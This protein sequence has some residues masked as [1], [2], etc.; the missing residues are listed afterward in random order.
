MAGLMDMFDDPQL[1]LG[2]GLLAA[3]APRA[4]AAGFGQRLM[5]GFNSAS[6][7]RDA[8][9]KRELQQI[10]LDEFKRKIDLEKRMGE[11]AKK[12]TTPAVA[13]V[14][15]E[16]QVPLNVAGD[17]GPNLFSNSLSN[18]STPGVAAVEAKPA[19][20]D[21]EGYLN[22]LSTV[23]PLKALEERA[24]LLPD[25]KYLTVGNTVV[26]TGRTG[27][28][29]VFTAPEKPPEATSDWKNYQAGLKDPGFNSWLTSQ[30]SAKAPK[31]AV[32]LKDPT[33][34][35][36]ASLEFQDKARA[37]FKDDETIAQQYNAMREAVKTPSAQGDT[38][39][40]YSFFKVLDPQSTVREGEL[41]LVMSSRSIPQKFKGYAQR[42]ANGQVL[43]QPE[44]EDLL[45]QAERQVTARIP[46]AERERKNYSANAKMLQLNP[47]DI[48]PN[49]Y[50]GISVMGSGQRA[51]SGGNNRQIFD[52]AD[53]I[54]GGN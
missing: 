21:Y 2:L 47:D 9:S 18:M 27:V 3:A 48:V 7:M 22:E 43:T 41:D 39:L 11:M 6:A 32:D 23:D 14:A 19:G 51:G 12:Y 8:K 52:S 34:V 53:A 42:L 16:A 46:K 35:A 33:A 45:K 17:T 4:D 29:P 54:V 25:P 49:P 28:K 13:G 31:V 44:R 15:G 37:A 36:K 1:Q 38:A 5:E 20:Y 10:Q 50:A 40:L 26:Q 24:K 30:Q